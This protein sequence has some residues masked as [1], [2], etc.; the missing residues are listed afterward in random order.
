MTQAIAHHI[1]PILLARR[2]LR[3]SGLLEPGRCE[4]LSGL[5]GP[6]QV[7]LDFAAD[8]EGRPLVRGQLRAEVEQRCE[9]CL[10]PMLLR[11]EPLVRW[12]FTR[13]A[14][15]LTDDGSLLEDIDFEGGAVD[16]VALIEDELLLAV[17]AYP[18]H[19]QACSTGALAARDDG[20]GP[21]TGPASGRKRPFVGLAGLLGRTPDP[22][23]EHNT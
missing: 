5:L 18:R 9:R 13:P 4:R 10:Q 8:A 7:Q 2:G 14:D 17:P 20:D 21:A 11:L 6:V 1:E 23:G 22:S 3:L 15:A 16:L 12:R 19:E